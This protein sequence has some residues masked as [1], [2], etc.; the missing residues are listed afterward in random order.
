LKIEEQFNK[1]K[2]IIELF[3]KRYSKATNIPVEEFE[4]ALCEEF[5]KKFGSYDGRIKFTAFIKPILVQCAMRVA[6]RKE[7][8]FYDNIVHVDGLQDEDGS[9]MFEFA[10]ENLTDQV[11]LERI[12]KSPDKLTLVRALIEKS[13]EF[14]VA[15]VELSLKNP[16]ASFNS[17][18]AEMGVHHETLKRKLK[19]LAKNYDQS[20]FGD[21]SQYLAV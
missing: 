15:A 11:A 10:D 20:R 9:D 6:A 5:S 1:T 8:K 17:I 3:A 4:S 18:A 7:R 12:E 16:D 13:D 21:I 19:R 2:P 14:T